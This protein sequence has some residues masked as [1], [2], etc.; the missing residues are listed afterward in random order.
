MWRIALALLLLAPA[1]AAAPGCVTSGLCA[2]AW[3]AAEGACGGAGSER[4]VAD[5]HAGDARVRYVDAHVET[6]CLRSGEERYRDVLVEVD[7]GSGALL[8]RWVDDGE[9]TC[10]TYAARDGSQL[11]G[12]GCV[13]APPAMPAIL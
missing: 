1:A 7:A 10:R 11:A 3:S 9:G 4:N 8:L 6:V 5:A 12:V 13:V 2:E